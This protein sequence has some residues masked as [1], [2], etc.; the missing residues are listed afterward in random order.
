MIQEICERYEFSYTILPIEAIFDADIELL[1]LRTPTPEEQKALEEEKQNDYQHHSTLA[2]NFNEIK[3]QVIE[4][5]DVD[6]KRKHFKELIE[7]LPIESSFREDLIFY[8]KRILISEFCLK[9]NFKK[10]L[11]GTNSH[12]VASQL[13]G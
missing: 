11:F 10:A 4:I 2:E 5:P 13:L 1:D 3:D 6:Q 12:K 7:C 8:L 9:Y